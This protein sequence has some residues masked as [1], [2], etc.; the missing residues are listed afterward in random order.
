MWIFTK[1]AVLSTVEY[2]PTNG[3]ADDGLAPKDNS[4]LW[5]RARRKSH[6]VDFGFGGHEVTETPENDYPFRVLALRHRVAA[7]VAN[8]VM[9]IDYENY[10][11][12]AQHALPYGM[13]S[14][15]WASVRSHLDSREMQD[16]S[17]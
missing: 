17:F 6:L 1:N 8:E 4:Q 12:A 16:P 9:S 11:N 3:Y 5:V 10:K 2:D 13:L 7:M 15:V 14:E